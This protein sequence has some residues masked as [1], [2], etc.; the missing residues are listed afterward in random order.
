MDKEKLI[1]GYLVQ[2]LS[3]EEEETFVT[4]LASDEAF[5]KAYERHQEI[6]DASGQIS[7]DKVPAFDATE[8]W[9]SFE[10]IIPETPVRK[11]KPNYFRTFYRVAAV[12]LL[13][14]SSLF[15]V[16]TF[17]KDAFTPGLVYETQTKSSVQGLS[18]GSHVYLDNQTTLNIDK[19]F[20]RSSRKMRLNGKA[21]FVVKPNKDKVFEVVT[22]HLTASVKGTTFLVRTDDH[23]STV[24]VK[25]GIVEVHVGS[26]TVTL[27]AGDQIDFSVDKGGVVKRSELNVSD[28]KSFQKEVM[29]YYDTPL[30]VILANLKES[31]GL[32]IVAPK[33]IENEKFTMELAGATEAEIIHTIELVTN[34]KAVKKGQIYTLF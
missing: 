18:D 11:L 2:S 19:Q 28:L 10:K 32:D 17:K 26:Q 34:R 27:T 14:L 23:S 30:K 29:D 1:Y 7:I 9:S 4:M 13:V 3:P 31:T 25:T 33:S 8:S 5:A 15:V 12:V 16:N 21:F 22:N 24:G 20:N 6:W